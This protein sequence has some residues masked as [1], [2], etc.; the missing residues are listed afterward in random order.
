M[1]YL[2]YSNTSETKDFLHTTPRNCNHHVHSHV[3]HVLRKI[4]KN[5]LVYPA[6]RDQWG[7]KRVVG[8]MLP[9]IN[10]GADVWGE[11]SIISGVYQCWCSC[12][13]HIGWGLCD[14]VCLVLVCRGRYGLRGVVLLFILGSNLGSE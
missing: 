13:L 2:L 5:T 7:G 1:P 3:Q 8:G 4:S 6:G 9:R 14:R 11:S 10:I 12:A